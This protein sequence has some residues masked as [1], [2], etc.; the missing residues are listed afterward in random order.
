MYTIITGSF[1]GTLSSFKAHELGSIVIKE[2]LK[3]AN[4]CPDEVSEVIIGQVSKN[5]L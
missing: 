2:V 4:V 3:R 5:T 1:C